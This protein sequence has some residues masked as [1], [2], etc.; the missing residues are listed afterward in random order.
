LLPKLKQLDLNYTSYVND[1]VLAA[2]G[3]HCTYLTCLGLVG[4]TSITDVG[5][6]ATCLFN[7]CSRLRRINLRGC[8]KLTVVSI[9]TI[10]QRCPQLRELGLSGL[11]IVSAV[12]IATLVLSCRKL[13]YLKAELWFDMNDGTHPP[14]HPEEED[15]FGHVI[16]LNSKRTYRVL[17]TVRGAIKYIQSILPEDDPLIP[18]L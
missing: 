11:T 13:K 6:S 18:L 7:Q 14:A 10:S 9:K 5:L 8:D 4:C 12:S 3:R 17:S 16:D 1:D 15:E 2:L